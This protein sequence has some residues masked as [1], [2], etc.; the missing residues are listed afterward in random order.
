MGTVLTLSISVED[1]LQGVNRVENSVQ[2]SVTGQK[3]KEFR[4]RAVFVSKIDGGVEDES[5][6]C[7]VKDQTFV[8]PEKKSFV[9]DFSEGV[10]V[11]A[12][13]EEALLEGR[14]GLV[15]SN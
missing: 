4:I 8:C 10:T 9:H 11:C 7:E 2:Q 12:R 1:I 13:P 6:L 14:I 15:G 5:E 3:R